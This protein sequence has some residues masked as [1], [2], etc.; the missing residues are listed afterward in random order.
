MIMSR[1]GAAP[2]T[3]LAGVNTTAGNNL[4]G[5]GIKTVAELAN[6]KD[7]NV[8]ADKLNVDSARATELVQAAKFKIGRLA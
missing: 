5:A 1:L 2:V 7:V 4:A 3:Y 8:L 6:V